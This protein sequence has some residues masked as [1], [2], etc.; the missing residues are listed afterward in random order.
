LGVERKIGVKINPCPPLQNTSPRTG[1][2][3]LVR[4]G[5][6]PLQYLVCWFDFNN[7]NIYVRDFNFIKITIF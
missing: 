5:I 3:N 4:K 7:L 6:S 2:K 1:Y